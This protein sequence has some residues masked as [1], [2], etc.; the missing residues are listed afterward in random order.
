MLNSITNSKIEGDEEEQI[1]KSHP[2]NLRYS[3]S[4]FNSEFISDLDKESNYT[5]CMIQ[6]S[7]LAVNHKFK[8]ALSQIEQCYKIS[9]KIGDQYKTNESIC[10]IGI[11]SIIEGTFGAAIK[12]LQRS[13]N[14][15]I[16][17]MKNKT[18]DI[19]SINLLL[20]SKIGSNLILA[21]FLHNKLD[22]CIKVMNSMI[23]I[24]NQQKEN[25]NKLNILRNIIFILFRCK[26]LTEQKYDYL[27]NKDL[28][29]VNEIIFMNDDTIIKNAIHKIF[30][31]LNNYLKTNN[32]EQFF[33]NVV[34]LKESLEKINDNK[35]LI[36]IIYSEL[37][38]MYINK[39]KL[40][41]SS[42][43]IKFEEFNDINLKISALFKAIK[44]FDDKLKNEDIMEKIKFFN[45]KL[46]M[47]S[48]LYNLLYENE[49][50]IYELIKQ[51]NNI[52]E[53]INYDLVKKNKKLTQES[54][55]QLLIN[56][57][58]QVIN[59]IENIEKDPI[60]IQ[61]ISQLQD[62]I[63]IL[64][65]NKNMYFSEKAMEPILKIIQK[66]KENKLSY[67][68]KNIYYKLNKAKYL[69]VFQINSIRKTIELNNEKLQK[70][71]N[72]QYQNIIEGNI[73]TK[74]NFGNN[75][76]KEHFYRVNTN[77][78]QIDCFKDFKNMCSGK[79]YK[80]LKF[81]QI[82]KISFGIKTNNLIN[83]IKIVPH[84][85]ETWKFLSFTSNKNSLDLIFNSDITTKKWFYGI[86][87]ILKNAN[88]QFKINSATGYIIL[89]LKMVIAFKLGKNTRDSHKLPFLKTIL[90]YCKD[91]NI[92]Y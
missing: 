26:S 43:S 83:K 23:E 34:K 63:T 53:S 55:K 65:N 38:I 44:V 84:S 15:Y 67:I 24:I 39:L 28:N 74:L 85:S 1:K 66:T 92:G 64:E 77:N 2:K 48:K 87:Y 71:Y 49:V 20:F 80:I 31:E 33:I 89:K 9:Q 88:K 27:D 22:D 52:K 51:E 42:N 91:N 6:G 54:F 14:N 75:G 21:L 8:E 40:K 17:D 79:P 72:Y 81:N 3:N 59:D 29:Q 57:I 16:D 41:K 90:N 37:E 76:I 25:L 50:V 70:F 30:E 13:F 35:G 45:Q 68:I 61:V 18:F 4:R 58:K 11:I 12:L 5:K 73:I 86:Q 62:V 56:I 7:N 82:N 36:F 10:H 32:L 69:K 19:G 47:A 46:E 60:K 78:E